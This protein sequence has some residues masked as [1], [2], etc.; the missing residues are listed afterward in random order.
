M[1]KRTDSGTRRVRGAMVVGLMMLVI[2]PATADEIV[3]TSPDGSVT[4]RGEFA[5]FEDGNYIVNLAPDGTAQVTAGRV[6]CEGRDCLSEKE[7]QSTR[8]VDLLSLGS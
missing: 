5:G 2:S 6:Y 7:I 3:L 1:T 4:I 8:P